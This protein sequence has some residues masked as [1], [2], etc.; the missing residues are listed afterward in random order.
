VNA[1]EEEEEDHFSKGKRG[2]TTYYLR[3]KKFI[4]LALVGRTY[5]TSLNI[6][7]FKHYP[8]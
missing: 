8:L 7:P 1:E 3:T 5:Y 2:K 6:T 4:P